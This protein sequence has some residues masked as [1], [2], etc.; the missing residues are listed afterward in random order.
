MT[1][2]KRIEA[3]REARRV[4]L[5]YGKPYVFSGADVDALL[6]ALDAERLAHVEA[7]EARARHVAELE[8]RRDSLRIRY[9]K[10][11]TELDDAH[12]RVK[13]LLP[14]ED[15]VAA[16]RQVIRYVG[17]SGACDDICEAADTL[18]SWVDRAESAKR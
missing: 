8:A 1:F 10:R 5:T 15:E 17:H 2:G 14:T 4:E 9:A 18:L 3:L 13:A 6:A 11:G 7:K 12:A 16:A